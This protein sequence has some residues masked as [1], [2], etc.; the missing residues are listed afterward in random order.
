MLTSLLCGRS[1]PRVAR[2]SHTPP[3]PSPR[4]PSKR[5][6]LSLSLLVGLAPACQRAERTESR[7]TPSLRDEP[8]TQPD[9]PQMA[10]GGVTRRT[11]APGEARALS[12]GF[13]A[14]A[15]AIRPSVVRIDVDIARP[16]AYSARGDGQGAPDPDLPDFLRRFFQFEQGLPMPGAPEAQH[17]TGS[18][19]I[20]A[21]PPGHVLTNSHVIHG[22]TRVTIVTSD[23]KRFQAEVVGDDPETDVGVVRFEHAPD[24]LVAARLGDSGHLKVGEWALAVGSPLGLDQT[25]TAGIVSGLGKTGGKMRLSGERVRQ[26]IQTDALI[27]PGNSGGPLLNLDGEVIGVNTLINVGPGGSYGF[28]IPINQAKQV[29]QT[30]AKEGRVRYPYIGVMV[31][32]VQEMPEDVRSNLPKGSPEKGA[33]VSEVAPGGPAAHAGLA[34]GD[35]IVKLD[36]HTVESSGEL[37]EQVSAHKIGDKVAL[38]YVR[39]GEAKRADIKIGELPNQRAQADEGRIGL[40]LQTLTDTLADALGVERGTRGAAVVEVRSGSP[41]ERAGL[42]PGDVIVQVDRQG[43]KSAEDVAERL[44]QNSDKPHL[45]RVLGPHGARFVTLRPNP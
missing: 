7:P 40:T 1:A 2:R 16:T 8:K 26:Y 23:S 11:P 5:A 41:A 17:G 34:A 32:D 14:A 25:V 44:E 20:L 3:T 29:A 9:N 38:E 10:T 43:V 31:G 36:G 39:N 37:I 24:G 13:A 18:G 22:A 6:L 35:I 33:F 27:N 19:F 4:A 28:A 45:L 30:L 21:Q 15:A 12:D 42:Q